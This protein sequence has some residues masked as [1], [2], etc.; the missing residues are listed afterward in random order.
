MTPGDG[1]AA[2]HADSGIAQPLV[3]LEMPGNKDQ[4][5]TE[6]GTPLLLATAVIRKP[7]SSSPA[8]VPSALAPARSLLR[9]LPS[10]DE[11]GAQSFAH[12][13]STSCNG[14]TDIGFKRSW[15]SDFFEPSGALTPRP[16]LTDENKKTNIHSRG[17]TAPP[18]IRD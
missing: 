5:W 14:F 1:L 6:L 2:K 9:L 11:G 3:F 10:I 16:S 13:A 18:P 15:T 12:I 7:K 8:G 17:L 4:L